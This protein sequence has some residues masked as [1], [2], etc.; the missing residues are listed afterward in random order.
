[1][2]IVEKF[3]VDKK[4]M[5]KDKSQLSSKIKPIRVVYFHDTAIFGGLEI[6]LLRFLSKLDRNICD[7]YVLIPGFTDIYRAS[8]PKFIKDVKSLG[9]PL[10]RP[11]DPGSIRG[12]DA[13]KEING[14]RRIFQEI[15]PDIVHMHTYRP[16]GA[17]K[18]T[19]AAKLAGVPVVVRTEHCAPTL[20]GDPSSKYRVRPFDK[21]TA[22]I[23]TVSESNRQ[24][25]L[26]IYKRSPDKTRTM[27]T[28]VEPQKFNP[29]HDVT[30]A[31]KALGFSEDL[32]V[33][34]AVGR[35]AEV[36]GF[37]YFV[38]AAHQVLNRYGPVNFLLVGGGPLEDELRESVRKLGIGDYFHMVGYQADPVPYI[39]AMDITVM[40]S[41]S[42]GLGLS[43]LEFMALGKSSVITDCPAM[44]EAAIDGIT[45]NVVQT[46][47]SESLAEGILK[48]LHDP[49]KARKMGEAARR[50]IETT[51]DFQFHV[52][53][54]M[55][56]Y[57]DL[58]VK[59]QN[60]F[61]HS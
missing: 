13:I 51:F 28:G 20:F 29:N 31:K 37:S 14:M 38:E 44:L 7:P 35:L 4:R 39:E 3:A 10:L 57:N 50:R 23:I 5:S 18:A 30:Q 59:P 56:L 32:P 36:K 54:I 52:D 48:L 26:E 6:Y 16:E 15:S 60:V 1:M 42:E 47:N 41:L 27:Y 34:G 58:V 9:V 40:S 21:L 12:L 2:T 49:A 43:L 19:L 22:E 53:E 17:Q 46:K 55:A 33:V 61:V 24:E 11:D 8:P 25:Q 45:C